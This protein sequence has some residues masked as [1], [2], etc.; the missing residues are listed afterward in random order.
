MN[1]TTYPAPTYPPMRTERFRGDAE[2][3]A[4]IG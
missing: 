1:V 4:A 2:R 3:H